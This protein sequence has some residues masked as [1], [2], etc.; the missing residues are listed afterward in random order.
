[1][2]STLTQT[3]HTEEEEFEKSIETQAYVLHDSIYEAEKY[4]KN[5]VAA[6]KASHQRILQA[7]VV[8]ID[9]ALCTL[10]G[11]CDCPIGGLVGENERPCERCGGTE[12]VYPS[13]ID[14]LKTTL[15][16]AIGDQNHT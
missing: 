4:K 5:M 7:V 14:R 8:E 15:I 6:L 1:M 13:E 12:F 16:E 10:K 2:T 11:P 9:E 3:I